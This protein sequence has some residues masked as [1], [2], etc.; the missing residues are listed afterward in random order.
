MSC[1]ANRAISILCKKGLIFD[2]IFAD[3]PY[4][5]GLIDKTVEKLSLS[6]IAP[7][8]LIVA[9]YADGDAIKTV[10]NDLE[11]IDSR[12]YGDTLLSFFKR[13]DKN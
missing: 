8:T 12:K 5:K 1:E 2:L 11:M 3:P 7:Q 10:Y 9:E 4:R 6:N 13:R